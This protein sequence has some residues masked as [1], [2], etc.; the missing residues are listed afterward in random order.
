MPVVK[1]RSPEITMAIGPKPVHQVTVKVV[2][3]EGKPQENVGVEVH[4]ADPVTIA[5]RLSFVASSTTN[6]AGFAYFDGLWPWWYVILGRREEDDFQTNPIFFTV[7]L[8]ETY[9][10]T[11]VGTGPPHI[12]KMS[13]TLSVIPAGFVE[14]VIE[15]LEALLEAIYPVDILEVWVEENT[16]YIR[17]EMRSPIAVLTAI[18]IILGLLVALGIVTWFIIKEIKPILPPKAIWFLIGGAIAIGAAAGLVRA[19]KK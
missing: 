7:A 15:R 4:R 9:R 11:T 13:I 12:F 19:M 14:W 10:F 3:R 17:F 8:G 18:I 1:V 5:A 2:N 6:K 16:C